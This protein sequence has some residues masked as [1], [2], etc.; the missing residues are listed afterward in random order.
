MKTLREMQQDV[1][2]LIVEEWHNHYWAPLSMLAR[3]SEEVGELAR[4]L[5]ARYGE[6]PKKA[7]EAEGSVSDEIG[8][9]LYILAAMA[10]SFDI[11]LNTAFEQV[12]AK[13][14]KRD[15]NRWT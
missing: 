3:L 6:K 1:D 2:H 8:D 14:R 10:N 5:N 15:A 13:Y 11:D 7:G 9:I 4:E 12:M